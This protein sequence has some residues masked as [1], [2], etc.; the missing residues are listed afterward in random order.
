MDDADFAAEHEYAARQ[1]ALARHRDRPRQQEA[2]RIEGGA[3]LCRDCDERIPWARLRLDARV[4]RCV[5]CQDA[6]E[7]RN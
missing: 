4:V 1:D 2:P 3:R 7:K 5:E 6:H